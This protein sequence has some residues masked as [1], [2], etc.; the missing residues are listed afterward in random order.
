MKKILLFLLV[1]FFVVAGPAWGMSD[2]TFS[3]YAQTSDGVGQGNPCYLVK[4]K[5]KTDGTN[6]LTLKIYDNATT[7]SGNVVAEFTII[8][9]DLKGGETFFDL[10]MANGIYVDMTVAGAGTGTW[11]VEF[12][13]P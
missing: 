12:K 3:S 6:N 5:G 4:V 7:N 11:W 9:A 2:H 13:K 1:C 8:G 10:R